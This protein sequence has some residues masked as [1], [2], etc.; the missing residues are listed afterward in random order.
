MSYCTGCQPGATPAID[1]MCYT[2]CNST[3]NY[4]YNGSCWTTCPN[5]TYVTFTGVTCAACAQVCFTCSS[6]S[7]TCLTCKSSY[8]YGSTCLTVCPS[9]FYGDAATLTCLNCS[10]SPSTACDKPLNFTT[11]YSVENYQG[12]I[13]LQFNQNVSLEKNLQDILNIN[14]VVN[15]R[16]EEERVMQTIGTLVNNGVT[17]TY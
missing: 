15:R 14:L 11:S 3:A 16:L 6:T 13:T 12:V 10:S 1:H 17:Y 8:H 4:S 7:T 9:G 5:G 2:N